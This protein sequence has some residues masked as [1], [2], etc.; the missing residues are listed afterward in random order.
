M[1]VRVGINGFGRIGRQSLKAL[2]ERAPDVE[3]VAVNDIVDVPTNALLFKHDSTYGS[4]PGEVSHT[5]DS[6]VVDGREIKVLQV[7]DPADLPWKDLG[8]DIVIE[9]TGRFTDADKARAHLDAGAKKVLISAP[10]KKRGRHDRPR[11]QRRRLRPGEAPHHQQR[12]LH[13]ELPGA[14]GQGRPRRLDDQARAHEHDPLYTNDQRIL[15]VAHKDPRRARAAGLNI[16]PTTTGAAKALA[17]VIPDLK[18]KFDGFSLRVPTPTV[19]R[20][21]LHGRARAAT[22]RSRSSTRPSA[23]PPPGR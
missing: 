9:S 19:S 6:I 14:G 21:R 13:D 15:D 17:L 3:V 2:I 8:V 23:P 20:R 22:P 11:R 12:Q 5:A 10:A 18:G 7:A 4:Y 1:S 16:I